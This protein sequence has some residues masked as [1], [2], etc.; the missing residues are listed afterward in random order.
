MGSDA[1]I[2]IFRHH[3]SPCGPVAQGL[4][5]RTHN[6]VQCPVI[7]LNLHSA[8]DAV[9]PSADAFLMGC[10]PS[11]HRPRGKHP[12]AVQQFHPSRMGI[13]TQ[14]DLAGSFQAYLLVLPH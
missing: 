9:A 14:T 6:P 7:P 2:G 11:V 13:Q 10:T 12:L 4:E 3:L 5:Q 1:S 8:A